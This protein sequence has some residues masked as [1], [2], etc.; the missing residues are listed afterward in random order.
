MPQKRI[1]KGGP[2]TFY[3]ECRK[4]RSGQGLPGNAGDFA[5]PPKKL[6]IRVGPQSDVGSTEGEKM[7]GGMAC[8]CAA[9]GNEGVGLMGPTNHSREKTG[10]LRLL[11]GGGRRKG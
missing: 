10:A 1:W 5:E 2:E 3:L 9:D 11:G 7:K 8:P 6:R 4:I